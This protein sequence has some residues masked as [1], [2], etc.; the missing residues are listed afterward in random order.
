MKVVFFGTPHFAVEILDALLKA[1]I[2]V[3]AVVTRPDQP[4]GRSLKLK[5]S[6]VKQYLA[7]HNLT[8]DLF[9]PE[10]ASA[11]D[12]ISVLKE[13][14]PDF[15]VVVGYG[16]ILKQSLLDVP[17][18]CPINIHTS[19][20]PS[21]RGAAPIQR[22]MMAAE[23]VMGIT[24][25]KMNAKMDAG[26]I[27]LQKSCDIP[28]L[29][30]FLTVENKL[31]KLSKEAILE[32]LRDYSHYNAHAKVQ[33]LSLVSHAPKIEQDDCL[34]NLSNN[35][36]KIQRQIMALSPKPGAFMEVEIAGQK[37][38]IKILSAEISTVKGARFSLFTQDGKLFFECN[39]GSIQVVELQLEGKSATS[40]KDFLNGHKVHFPIKILKS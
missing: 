14:H 15:F 7:D 12:F 30:T 28:I 33:N 11:P 38:R 25:M 26:E 13:K 32:V 39:E 21:Y 24:V 31:I 6:P 3:V 40:A 9:Q 5:P 29:D 18:F 2:Q 36:L 8:I 1:S 22:A 20:L 34:I 37:K 10:K 4:Q 17:K 19:L 27:L 35:S 23:K 16:E